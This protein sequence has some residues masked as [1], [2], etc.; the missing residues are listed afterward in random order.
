MRDR[1]LGAHV[2]VRVL[3]A[4]RVRGDRHRL[5]ERERV[6]LHEDAVLERSGL[7]LVRVADEVVRLHGLLRDGL[8]L[9]AGRERGAAAA[10]QPRLLDLAQ[11]ALLAELEGAAKRGVA[12]VRA[13]GV[14]RLRIEVGRDAPQQAQAGL[15]ALRQRRAVLRQ[16]H[17]A[18]LRAGDRA[19]RRRRALAEAEARRRVRAR[20]NLGARELAGEIGADVQHVGRPFLE[21]DQRVEGRD[22]VRLGRRH[23]EPARRVAERALAHPADP[24][25]C[26]A[27]RGEEQV[28]SRAVGARDATVVCAGA[29]PRPCRSPRARRR[30]ARRRAGGGP[31]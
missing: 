13:V 18:R 1:V 27:K 5:D 9:R 22:A 7:G 24:P 6:A 23:V 25:L 29:R 17:L 8:P 16:R 2:D 30:S 14:E 31:R 26:G 12:A 28:P 19:Q 20:R 4:G 11:H 10:E 21:R 3:A 15:A